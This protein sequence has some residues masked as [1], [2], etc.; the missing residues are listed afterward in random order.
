[1]LYKSIAVNRQHHSSR[2]HFL[3]SAAKFLACARLLPAAPEPTF[4]SDVKVVNV[5]ATV[6]NKH[7]EIIRDLTKDD[8]VLDEDGRTQTIRY[9]SQ[10]TNLPLTLGLLVD[11][12]MSQRR[13]LGEERSASFRF[14]S[15]VL[16]EDKD[17]G[18]VIHFDH[19]VE[20]LQDLT[21]A[22]KQLEAALDQLEVPQRPARSWG[23]AG[24]SRRPHGGRGF[25]GGGTALYDSI[26]LASDELM[27]KQT[28]RKALI[29]LSDGVDHGSRTS[30]STAI[31]AAQRADTLVYSI[32][33]ADPDM[34]NMRGFGGGGRGGRR[35]GPSRMPVNMRDGKKV[36]ESAAKET[37]GGFFEVSKKHSIEQIYDTVQ[38]EL[39][40]QY[41]LGYTPNAAASPGYRKIHVATKKKDLIVQAR[42]GYYPGA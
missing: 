34:Y 5:F 21:S 30:L 13:V 10:E 17:M 15:Q 9:F 33:F 35:G 26:L 20:L 19:D 18:F 36:L 25:G 3:T 7:G 37:G 29:L 14:L 39:R 38:Q 2:R 16:R 4:S 23:G 22:R 6:R 42:E 31:E 24:G 1:M 28:G 27:K 41:S 40:Y 32:L 11:T 12:S 8:F